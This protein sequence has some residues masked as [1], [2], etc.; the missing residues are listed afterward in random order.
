M[1]MKRTILAG[2]LALALTG[3]AVV[4]LAD[5]DKDGVNV[6]VVDM[7]A[8]A[9]QSDQL[10][11]EKKALENKFSKRR[12][13]IVGMQ[14]DLASKMAKYQKEQAVMKAADR[15]TLEKAIGKVQTSLQAAQA[16]YEKDVYEAQ[17][18]AMDAVLGAIRSATKKVAKKHHAKLVLA[19]AMAV[20]VDS[21]L[22]LT[23][24][25]KDKLG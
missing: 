19:K 15:A 4:A 1:T 24:E 12:E 7:Q 3:V 2:G 8:I 21:D 17:R 14:K 11:D 13:S 20:Y 6:A 5:S 18:K 10:K 16:S 9:A 22:D 23:D 25:V